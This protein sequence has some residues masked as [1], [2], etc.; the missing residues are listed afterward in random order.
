M[1][2]HS[3]DGKLVQSVSTKPYIDKLIELVGVPEE[4]QDVEMTAMEE[5]LGVKRG[6]PR[7]STLVT[8]WKEVMRVTYARIM[9]CKRGEGKYHACL[10]DEKVDAA[11]NRKGRAERD[12]QKAVQILDTVN[13][14]CLSEER[15]GVYD[16][17]KLAMQ[18]NMLLLAQ[19][20]K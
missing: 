5:A 13:R 15:R 10:D 19:A 20:V 12:V 16:N 14:N 3:V 8:R 9:V 4:G 11:M 18:R 2:T 7:W 17:V 6:T 1:M